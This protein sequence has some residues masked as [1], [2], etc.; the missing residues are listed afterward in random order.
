MAVKTA[1]A[2]LRAATRPVGII[3]IKDCSLWT[4]TF[5]SYG[6]FYTMKKIDAV[7]NTLT[8]ETLEEAF[9]RATENFGMPD[10]FIF[11]DKQSAER[12]RKML[13]PTWGMTQEEVRL[14]KMLH[15]D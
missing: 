15:E 2:G 6:R 4:K 11:S 1:N 14:W 13:N 3:A 9:K 7:P 5:L 10:R 12:W 8:A